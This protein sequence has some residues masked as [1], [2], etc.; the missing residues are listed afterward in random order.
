[1]SQRFQHDDPKFRRF[2]SL[3]DEG[4]RLFTAETVA[5]MTS[6]SKFI[7]I[8]NRAYASVQK[9][10]NEMRHFYRS[11]VAEHKSD[12]KEEEP[13]K[14]LVDAYLKQ[15][16]DGPLFAGRNPER[17]VEQVIGD[18]FSAGSETVQT[19]LRWAVVFALREPQEQL[20][21]QQELDRVVGPGR[22]PSL[23]D[24][25]NLPRTEAF[26]MEVM[27]RATAVPLGTPHAVLHAVSA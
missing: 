14:D 27:R 5:E 2:I 11:V 10:L 25:P 17:Q 23:N 1:M 4:F 3:F 13:A 15:P 22:L 20:L 8:L 19:T 21:V 24:R 9:N 12:L 18:L 7:P 26:L 16:A 6:V